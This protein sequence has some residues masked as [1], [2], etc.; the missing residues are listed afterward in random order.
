[1]N[2]DG[3]PE[4]GARPLYA[5]VLRLRHLSLGTWQRA[6]LAEG[7]LAVGVLLALADLASAWTIVVLP[8]VVAAV[9]KAHDV[10][11]GDLDR[12]E[13]RAHDDRPSRS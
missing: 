13:L 12:A 3:G 9:V 5:R 2:P 1:M 11:Q 6:A 4:P 8:V 10:L 7:M